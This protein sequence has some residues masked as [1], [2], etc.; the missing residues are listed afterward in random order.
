MSL[1]QRFGLYAAAFEKVVE[2]NDPSHIE[3]YFTEDA[4]YETIGG[5]PFDVVLS[6]RDAVCS[7][8]IAS[9]DALDR[10]FATRAIELLQGPEE[11]GDS[12][13]IAWRGTYSQPGLPDL[14]FDG[15]ETAEFEG[16]RIRRLEDVVTA[17]D[18]R[19]VADYLE[20]HAA[21]LGAVSR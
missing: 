10:R 15:E 1:I 11:R 2:T 21:L 12:V 17:E 18:A 6:G 16:D 14:V 20:E 9:L 7:G 8:L 3:P 5:P 19:R 13:W 4:V